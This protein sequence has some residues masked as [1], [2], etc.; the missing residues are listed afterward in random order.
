MIS[1]AIAFIVVALLW[2]GTNPWLKRGSER[3]LK[4]KKK[5]QTEAEKWKLLLTSPSVR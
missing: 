5:S 2:G 4:H 1:D 3:V